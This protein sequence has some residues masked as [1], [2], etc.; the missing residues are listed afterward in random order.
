MTTCTSGRALRAAFLV[1]TMCFASP[2]L[3]GVASALP[4]NVSGSILVNNS[5]A[6]AGNPLTYSTQVPIANGVI[7]YI[8]LE[9]NSGA[10]NGLPPASTL[11]S[12]NATLG[13]AL[14]GSTAQLSNDSTFVVYTLAMTTGV[15]PVN[16]VITFTPLG[17][18]TGND[19]SI[20]NLASLAAGG[21]P[22]N[23][24]I[25]IGSSAN[26][27]SFMQDIDSF[28]T[29]TIIRVTGT[30]GGGGGG[31]IGGLAAGPCTVPVQPGYW[32]NP[33]EP[34]RGFFIEQQGNTLYIAGFMYSASGHT[35]WF[36]SSGTVS[37]TGST[38]GTI[39]NS[40]APLN[41]FSGGQTLAGT[42]VAPQGP[43]SSVS[44]EFDLIDAA[45]GILQTPGAIIPIQRYP[46]LP[47]TLG[48]G[49]GATQPVTG[50]WWNPAESGRGYTL[51]IQQNSLYYATFM[52]D[53]S[54]SP[55]WYLTGPGSVDSHG[56]YS[57]SFALYGNGQTLGGAYLA[58][59]VVNA[60]VGATTLQFAT[61]TSGTMTYPNGTQ[62]PI[63]HFVFVTNGT[64]LTVS[65]LGGGTIT[66]NP[67]GI[68]CASSCEGFFN[69][70]QPVT[71]TAT[72]DSGSTFGVWYG[73]C[74]GTGSCRVT[75]GASSSV[76]AVFTVPHTYAVG[77]NV[78][79]PGTVTSNG[80]INC[81]QIG[82]VGC[83]AIFPNS[84]IAV[85]TATPPSD[86]STFVGWSGD[87]SSA[88]SATVCNLPNGIAH[89]VGALFLPP[90]Q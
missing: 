72:A 37:T 46:I 50:F 80:G 54:G 48:V 64:A 55:T 60:N 13:T 34:G 10:F 75:A 27:N 12:N 18:T 15:V 86:G 38:T 58:P 47:G 71:L 14:S 26:L 40:V 77:V 78:T 59:V 29:G 2:A 32:W 90:P 42:Y 1:L 65:S 67:S 8:Y 74:Q 66:S 82:G 51:E 83:G 73:A 49:P 6:I 36:Q 39:C 3:A 5:V 4:K 70:D 85:L 87:C 79:G 7:V 31:S 24:G 23:V 56:A 43:V 22:V 62:I 69:I 88:G 19:G 61:P 41:T 44:L 11:S 16:S 53:T 25:S 63:Q 89:S 81:M 52:Y 76:N 9:T 35:T 20:N 84:T 21:G 45:H 33:A 57:G 68:V 30:G 28:A 17:T